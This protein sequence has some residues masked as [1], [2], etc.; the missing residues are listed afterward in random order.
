MNP[1][2]QRIAALG[3]R[4]SLA[5][6]AGLALGLALW[7][8]GPGLQFGTGRPLGA[9]STR[10]LLAMLVMGAALLWAT[11]RSQGVVLLGLACLLIAQGGAAWGWASSRPLQSA[12]ARGGLIA[13]LVLAYLVHAAWQLLRHGASGQALRQ[14][15][16]AL[17]RLLQPAAGAAAAGVGGAVRARA[18]HRQWEQ[19]YARAGWIGRLRAWR[20]QRSLPWY[21]VLGAENSGKSSLLAG[22]ALRLLRCEPEDAACAWWLGERAVFIECA[23][24]DDGPAP[25]A[26]FAACAEPQPQ[27]QP[28]PQPGHA[29][30]ELA[31]PG[32][33]AAAWQALLE[34]L[35]GRG[36]ALPLHGIVLAVDADRLLRA[37]T[38]RAAQAALA[39]RRRLLQLQTGLGTRIPV[40]LVL[41]RVDALPGFEEFFGA[42]DSQGR[43]RVHDAVWG[44]TMAWDGE[45][46]GCTMR[47]IDEELELLHRRLRQAL[48]IC[49]EQELE[50]QRRCRMYEFPHAYA[51]LAR[52][53]HAWIDAV[54][55]R[56][57]QAAQT[58]ARPH[59]PAGGEARRA[60]APLR[61]VYLASCARSFA[62]GDAVPP[63]RADPGRFAASLLRSVLLP[64]TALARPDDPRL[65]RRRARRW[66][67]TGMMLCATGAAAYA[68]R[69]SRARIDAQLREM[70]GGVSLLQRQVDVLRRDPGRAGDEAWQPVLRS[71]QQLAQVARREVPAWPFGGL[72]L[73]PLQGTVDA[74]SLRLQQAL[75]V[76]RLARSAREDLV[77]AMRADRPWQGFQSLRIY[78]M[79]H[80]PQLY[81]ADTLLTWSARHRE[82]AGLAEFALSHPA[83]VLQDRDA[84]DE[85]LVRSA[86]AWLLRQQ[87]GTRLWWLV[88]ERLPASQLP[89][90]FSLAAWQAAQGRRNFEAAVQS[91]ADDGVCGCFRAEAWQALIEPHLA[92]WAARAALEDRRILGDAAVA[93][94]DDLA[95][96]EVRQAYW[97]DYARHWAG[98]LG[99]L[100]ASMSSS[101]DARV[102]WLRTMAQPGSPLLGL[103]RDVWRELQPLRAAQAAATDPVA[104]RLSELAP[105]A[106]PDSAATRKLLGWLDAYLAAAGLAAEALRAG[107]L[108]D[109]QARQTLAALRVQAAVMPDPLAP[110]LQ[111]LG[112]DTLRGL[113][114]ALLER[115][116][117]HACSIDS[118]W[119][120]LP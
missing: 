98:F 105:F 70:G 103:V 23:A 17:R 61:G 49:L 95:A 28:Q 93:P 78:L 106:E 58:P 87:R 64:D 42:L 101:L 54:F 29:A 66:L 1:L 16:D 2:L 92:E 102:Q 114:P 39:V 56:W 44:F 53:L 68:V 109:A 63:Q 22:S 82:T 97:L 26:E 34:L 116:E 112:D 6:A 60:I 37:G 32:E 104:A 117:H 71:A 77:R 108:P 47:G 89:P 25:G 110:L 30:G 74:V 3:P 118:P 41:T 15:G 31:L 96:D 99:S 81:E 113:L 94:S 18:L 73:Q 65:R 72:V 83:G 57:P 69:D 48:A 120:H 85:P 36:A 45:A 76:P 7:V 40:Y 111:S 21:V 59:G 9:A 84:L 79:L 8:L 11:R 13:L 75:L 46:A 5:L 50:L 52:V 80:D 38:D 51:E 86:R 43:R 24:V 10:V 19:L 4:L 33:R 35:R 55:A 12:W 107:A 62:A 20:A 100:R 14:L 88:R 90:R 115:R 119:P 27:P 91:A 67:L